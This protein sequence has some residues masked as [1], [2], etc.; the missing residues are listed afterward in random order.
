MKVF[1]IGGMGLPCSEV[2]K[3]LTKWHPYDKRAQVDLFF[4]RVWK[5]LHEDDEPREY[6]EDCFRYVLLTRR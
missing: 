6:L 4:T 1:M 5:P 2:A 3:E